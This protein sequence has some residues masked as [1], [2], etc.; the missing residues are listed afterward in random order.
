MPTSQD[1]ILAAFGD[2]QD[3]TAVLTVVDDVV[4]MPKT[5]Y[6]KLDAAKWQASPH[7]QL[8]KSDMNEKLEIRLHNVPIGQYSHDANG[9][10]GMSDVE[11]LVREIAN[12][13]SGT[14]AVAYE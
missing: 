7:F 8:V 9:W 14:V 6:H 10:Q 11:A 13:L 1:R 12:A 2:I 4:M 5:A 3:G